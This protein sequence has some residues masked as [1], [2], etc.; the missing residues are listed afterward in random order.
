MQRLTAVIS[1]LR[2]QELS[3]ECFTVQVLVVWLISRGYHLGTTLVVLESFVDALA[4]CWNRKVVKIYPFFSL[5]VVLK[6]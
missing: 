6:L 3:A 1:H 5:A 2:S 4:S